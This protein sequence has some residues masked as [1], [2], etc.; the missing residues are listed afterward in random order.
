MLL[1]I[2]KF[3]TL[4]MILISSLQ[5]NYLNTKLIRAIDLL[6]KICHYIP[7]FILKTLYYALFNSHLI[8][9]CQIWGQ[10]EIMIR[11]RLDLKNKAM[12]IINFKTRDHPADALYHCNKILK[13][14]DYIELLNCMFVKNCLNN[15]QVTFELANNMHQHHTRHSANNSVMS[16]N[17]KDSYMNP[18]DRISS[19]IF[20][21]YLAEST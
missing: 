6:A 5:T 11:K 16:N 7:K 20:L 8:Y 4:L 3:N 19:S 12:R 21:E 13:I 14:T 10:K 18:F 15:F 17:H 9:V 2:T 1:H